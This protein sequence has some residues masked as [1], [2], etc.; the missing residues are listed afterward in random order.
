MFELLAS[1]PFLNSTFTPVLP[2][3]TFL[4]TNERLNTIAALCFL[5]GY[6]VR[7]I[8]EKYKAKK[9]AQTCSN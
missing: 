2:A 6:I 9:E 3:N 1:A 5:A 8:S 4:T 7:A